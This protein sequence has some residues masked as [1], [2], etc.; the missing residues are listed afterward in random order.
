MQC[1]HD[2]TVLQMTERHGIEIDY[3]PLA[4]GYGWTAASSTRSSSGRAH[5]PSDG[6]AQQAAV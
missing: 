5:R 1:P 6:A 3:C 4:A 2:Q